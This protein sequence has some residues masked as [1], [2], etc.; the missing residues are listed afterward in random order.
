MKCKEENYR[1]KSKRNDSK[2]TPESQVSILTQE[3]SGLFDIELKHYSGFCAHLAEEGPLDKQRGHGC[4]SRSIGCV[5]IGGSDNSIA[6][7]NSLMARAW[8]QKSWIM[9]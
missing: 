2:Y 7:F 5:Q 3:S 6:A 9:Q 8:V 1:I 4:N